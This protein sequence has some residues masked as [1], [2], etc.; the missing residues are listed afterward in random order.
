MAAELVVRRVDRWAN[1]ARP[2]VRDL[3]PLRHAD[4]IRHRAQAQFLH[5][6]AAMDFDRLFDR[7][8]IA[9]NLLVESA[10]DNL[11]KYLPLARGQGSEF[12]LD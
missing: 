2:L 7:T 1:K 10:R 11:G 3:G 9:G 5:H 6:S 8:Q 12:R 4:E